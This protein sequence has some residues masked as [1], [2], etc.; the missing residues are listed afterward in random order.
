MSLTISCPSLSLLLFRLSTSTGIM[1]EGKKRTDKKTKTK[2]RKDTLT[3]LFF[4]TKKIGW[5][6]EG[7]IG[8]LYEKKMVVEEGK[9]LKEAA[10]V[11]H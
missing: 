1:F 8:M 7:G 3:L 11:F 4:L 2:K 6:V 5:D 10:M 9:E